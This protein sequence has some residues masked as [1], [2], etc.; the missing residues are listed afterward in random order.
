MSEQRRSRTFLATA[1]FPLMH[2]VKQNPRHNVQLSFRFECAR[3]ATKKVT[4]TLYKNFCRFYFVCALHTARRLDLLMRRLA[5]KD[6]KIERDKVKNETTRF[7]TRR[8]RRRRR[9]TII[10]FCAPR[11]ADAD[12]KKK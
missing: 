10:K 11:V 9:R 7:A 3:Q 5:N 1:G 4:P 12:E 8:A 6:K 2:F